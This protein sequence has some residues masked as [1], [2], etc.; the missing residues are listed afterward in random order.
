[1]SDVTG[2]KSKFSAVFTWGGVVLLL[3]G[4]F[5]LI[6]GYSGTGLLVTVAGVVS[7]LF[8][9]RRGRRTAD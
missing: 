8:A 9:K 3:L 1:M 7:W 2:G 6:R 5:F 4:V